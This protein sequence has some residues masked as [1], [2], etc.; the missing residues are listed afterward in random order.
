MRLELTASGHE[1]YF[2]S[3]NKIAAEST[4]DKLSA[5]CAFPLLQD[6]VEEGVWELHNG[7]KDD[8]YIYDRDGNLAAYLP[9]AGESSIN[10]STEAGY[11]HVKNSLLAVLEAE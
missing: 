2:L 8:F 6:T 4:Q 10:L 9:N 5:R 3:V 7:N 11:T 1:V